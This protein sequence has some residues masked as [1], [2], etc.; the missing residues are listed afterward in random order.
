VIVAPEVPNWFG[1]PDFDG[2]I[3]NDSAAAAFVGVLAN[4]GYTR[5]VFESP[6]EP[7]EPRPA[8][9]RQWMTEVCELNGSLGSG[10]Y[11]AL[12]WARNLH[13]HVMS[14]T[15]AWIWWWLTNPGSSQTLITQSF[16]QNISNFYTVP[17]RFWMFGHYSRFVRPGFVRVDATPDNSSSVFVSAYTGE[18]S[19]GR[20]IVVI[21]TNNAS[22]EV[23]LDI[24]IVGLDEDANF[25]HYI[26]NSSLS[27]EPQL[28]VLKAIG[29]VV[30]AVL[31]PLSISTLV[32]IPAPLPPAPA[33]GGLVYV[34][35]LPFISASSG[36][37]SVLPVQRDRFCDAH[38]DCKPASFGDDQKNNF[39][40]ALS[41]SSVSRV[42]LHLGGKCTTFGATI[43]LHS[44]WETTA[45]PVIFSVAGDGIVIYKSAPFFPDTKGGAPTTQPQ[46]ITVST[47]GVSI[48]TL[49]V[50]IDDPGSL[51][52]ADA[53][54][55]WANASVLC[56]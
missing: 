1:E 32:A 24:S 44:S 25:T 42:L 17:T 7:L 55:L 56:P 16:R 54:P 40:K 36:V 6:V 51:G 26:T 50:T 21:A 52:K 11:D 28:T 29:G 41:V 49:Q 39:A 53:F 23:A 19:S 5:S 46:N 47:A 38:D 20:Q 34:S 10:M 13:R 37:D 48:L 35:D 43:G 14:G 45:P 15:Q 3:V 9:M 33:A 27:L 31:P 22:Q 8:S 18:A 12:G 4:H 2:A 30:S